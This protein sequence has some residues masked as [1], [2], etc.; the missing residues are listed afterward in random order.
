MNHFKSILISVLLVT[1]FLGVTV[2]AYAAEKKADHLQLT[3]KA[4]ASIL[5]ERDT[6]AVL[7]ENNSHDKLP[8]ASLT[9][10]MTLLLVMEAIESGIIQTNE[11]VTVSGNAA[12][13]GGSQ[14]FLEEGEQISVDNLIKS[15]AIASANDASVALAERIAGSETAFVQAMNNKAKAL[16]LENTNFQNSSGLPAAD[17]YTTAHDIAIIA[18]ELLKFEQITDYTSI[19]EDYLRK[20]QKN[21]FWLVNTNKLVR[22]YDYVDGLKTGYT[23]EAKFCLVATAKKDD[24]RV[25]SVIMG[26]DSS[27]ERNGMTMDLIDYAFS[28]YETEKLFEANEKVGEIYFLKSK[29]YKYDLKTNESISVLHAK[30]KDKA[31]YTSDIFVKETNELP[32]MKNTQIGTIQIKKD[33]QQ[34]V[35]YPLVLKENVE[36]ASIPTLMKRTLKNVTKYSEM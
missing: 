6:G 20:G 15:V 31:K 35:E 14:V 18:K 5:L 13:M 7:Y 1:L 3:E 4:K 22:F 12:S 16:K 19:Y 21:E 10:I 28:Q 24:M 30:G 29:K 33:N 25:I 34:T 2:P 8:P 23:S 11:I 27:K 32:I 26:A 36:L 17:H 9:K